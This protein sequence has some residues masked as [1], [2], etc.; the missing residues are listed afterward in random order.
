MTSRCRE[1]KSI[2][3]PH[4]DSRL[5]L[6]TVQVPLARLK[7]TSAQLFVVPLLALA[8]AT[9]AASHSLQE[10][11]QQLFKREKYFQAVNRPAPPFM[12]RDAAGRVRRLSD[13]RSKVVVLNFIYAKCPDVCPLHSEKIAQIQKMINETP[14]KTQ[15][16]FVT[17]TTDPK[18]DTPNVMREFGGAHGLN[19]SN[20]TFLTTLP[21]QSVGTTRRLAADYGLEFTTM[22][23]GMQMHGIVTHVIDQD[24]RLRARFH[25]LRFSPVSPVIYANAL[26]NRAHAPHPH[27]KREPTMWERVQRWFFPGA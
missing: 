4:R 16:A 2:E 24:G 25:S 26:V 9:Q 18:N 20:W 19:P 7:V 14:M 17:I 27:G 6:A 21:S 23:G 15:A 1:E 13:F 12:L 11:E 3:N 10:V 5:R 22:P 8:L